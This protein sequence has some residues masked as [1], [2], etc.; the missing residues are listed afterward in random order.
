MLGARA[1]KGT[2]TSPVTKSRK[3]SRGGAK[4]GQSWK[5]SE[6]IAFE[7]PHKP[8]W[9]RRN[10]GAREERA[11]KQKNVGSERSLEKTRRSNPSPGITATK[12]AEPV[13]SRGTMKEAALSAPHLGECLRGPEDEELE[14]KQ[15]EPHIKTPRR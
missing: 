15:K 7:R 5:S 9:L 14:S 1:Q 12:P 3:S 10:E 4:L 8:S 11:R 13:G 6:D 2:T